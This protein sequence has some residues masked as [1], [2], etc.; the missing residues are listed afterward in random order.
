MSS[1]SVPSLGVVSVTMTLPGPCT[2]MT[3]RS[4]ARSVPETIFPSLVKPWLLTF[5]GLDRLRSETSSR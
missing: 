3:Q 2:V 1:S 5:K 4:P